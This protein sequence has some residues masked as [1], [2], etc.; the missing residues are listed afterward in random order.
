[1]N[2]I[3]SRIIFTDKGREI[4]R[5]L[6]QMYPPPTKRIRTPVKLN[7]SS[8]EIN[9]KIVRF[10]PRTIMKQG[11]AETVNDINKSVDLDQTIQSIK[12][13]QKRYQ[14]FMR[15]LHRKKWIKIQN[16]YYH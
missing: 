12:Q 8:Q 14:E 16:H 3:K 13:Q 11:Y 4:Q 6:Y 5:E 10:L 2:Q 1:M 15:R 7:T 9:T